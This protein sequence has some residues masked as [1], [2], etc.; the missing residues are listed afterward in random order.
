MPAFTSKVVQRGNIATV[1][2]HLSH[3]WLM[4]EP[5]L[6]SLVLGFFAKFLVIL[7]NF[8]FGRRLWPDPIERMVIAFF[9]AIFVLQLV[10]NP[11]STENWN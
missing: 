10:N 7:L 11:D 2:K 6:R 9:T 4:S 8:I 1:F 5:L 3:N